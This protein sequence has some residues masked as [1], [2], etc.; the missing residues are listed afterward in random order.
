MTM[1]A[2]EIPML[3][4]LEDMASYCDVIIISRP[5]FEQPDKCVKDAIKKLDS[6]IK[7]QFR[8]L[9]KCDNHAC[10]QFL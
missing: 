9:I 2:K 6:E 3:K 5:S 4:Q 8:K 1:H 10:Y 7:I